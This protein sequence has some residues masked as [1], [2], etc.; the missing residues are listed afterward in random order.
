MMP[1]AAPL[2]DRQALAGLWPEQGGRGHRHRSVMA[3][4]AGRSHGGD[5]MAKT[6]ARAAAAAAAAKSDDGMVAV[7]CGVRAPANVGSAM[8][9]CAC[10]GAASLVHLHYAR[11]D[12]VNNRFW[13]QPQVLK[14]VQATAVG[15]APQFAA[16]VSADGSLATHQSQEVPRDM[17][18][19]SMGVAAY[20]RM[21]SAGDARPTIVLEAVQSAVSI[22]DFSFPQRCA[23]VVGSEHKGVDQVRPPRTVLLLSSHIRRGAD[24]VA[25]LLRRSCCSR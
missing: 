19:K 9:L 8:R 22:Y 15:T 10:F 23:I 6:R 7:L 11:D 20:A 25:D 2:V 14:E 4:G 24:F 1:A 12:T 16:P 5:T 3:H 13:T 21:L 17:P 18:F